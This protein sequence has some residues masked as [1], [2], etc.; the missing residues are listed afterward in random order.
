LAHLDF[1]GNKVD[2][3]IVDGKYSDF[4]ISPPLKGVVNVLTL[5]TGRGAAFSA[6]IT[7]PQDFDR[8][9]DAA[10]LGRSEDFS[11]SSNFWTSPALGLA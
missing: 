11:A 1:I 9:D 6:R 3:T 5:T 10:S 2:P 8:A 7:Y 4:S